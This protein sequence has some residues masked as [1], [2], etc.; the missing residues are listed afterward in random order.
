[1]DP[2]IIE[3][4]AAIGGN[5][6]RE[7]KESLMEHCHDAFGPPYPDGFGNSVVNRLDFKTIE[8]ERSGEKTTRVTVTSE[9]LVTKGMCPAVFTLGEVLSQALR[10]RYDKHAGNASRRMCRFPYRR[11]RFCALTNYA[12]AHIRLRT[13][14]HPVQY[15]CTNGLKD[16]TL[17]FL[18]M[19]PRR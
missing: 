13:A 2:S 15:A 14:V 6:S 4:A 17:K 3:R 19:S 18:K 7:E 5:A 1:M 12:H 16:P 8:V 9:L 10:A 11:V